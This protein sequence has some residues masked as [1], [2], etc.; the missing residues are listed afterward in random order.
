[1]P[2]AMA[3]VRCPG[4]GHIWNPNEEPQGDD[5]VQVATKRKSKTAGV[6]AKLVGTI[7]GVLLLLSV[8]GGAAWYFSQSE[9]RGNS[10]TLL[11]LQPTTSTSPPAAT[12]APPVEPYRE[13]SLSEETRKQIYRDYRL[14]S[15]TTVE[16]PIPLP[17]KWDSRAAVDA[18]MNIVLEREIMLHATAHNVSSD[19]I[20]EVIKEG[21]AKKWM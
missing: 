2:V 15:K 8:V 16:K 12:I 1:M 21:N 10:E 20:A 9:P 11:A 18:T 14:A 5:D 7:L 19:D 6:N 4:C 17:K 3:T 13:I